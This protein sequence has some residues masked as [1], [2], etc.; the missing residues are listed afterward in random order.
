MAASITLQFGSGLTLHR[1]SSP[2]CCTICQT[3]ESLMLQ[4]KLSMIYFE[5]Q[6]LRSYLEV[7]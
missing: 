7:R 5:A 1:V 4:S 6:S 2:F 3:L